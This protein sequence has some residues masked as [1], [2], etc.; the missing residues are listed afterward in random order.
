MSTIAETIAASL[1][2]DG[3]TFETDDGASIDEMLEQSSEYWMCSDGSTV[4]VFDD[5][6][7]IVLCDQFWDIVTV[8]GSRWVDSGGNEWAELDNDGE[9][10]GWA[11]RRGF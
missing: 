8:K 7:M 5:G 11:Y 2:N 6:S 9:P 3:Q 4:T 1:H 10:Y